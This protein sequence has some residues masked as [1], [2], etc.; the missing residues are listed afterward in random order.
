MFRIILAAVLSSF[1]PSSIIGSAPAKDERTSQFSMLRQLYFG[2]V[3]EGLQEFPLSQW[4]MESGGVDVDG[5][6]VLIARFFDRDDS[7]PIGARL[8]SS[9][10]LSHFDWIAYLPDEKHR[11]LGDAVGITSHTLFLARTYD[12]MR[13]SY[14]EKALL[15]YIGCSQDFVLISVGP[16]RVPN[17]LPFHYDLR[18][19]MVMRYG[20][21]DRDGLRRLTNEYLPVGARGRKSRIVIPV[22]L[23]YDPT[24]GVYS[25]GDIV[26][27]ASN[28]PSPI[29]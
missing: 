14:N 18:G 22:D 15:G 4:Q 1:F 8:S 21:I 28:D 17:V 3:L 20:T 13:D 23:I 16:D 27:Q 2:V 9:R 5:E 19:Q 6:Y 29:H 10:I 12:L 11:V 24:N 25:S 7:F 26:Y